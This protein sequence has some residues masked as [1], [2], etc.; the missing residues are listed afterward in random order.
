MINMMRIDGIRQSNSN[1]ELNLRD[2][3][4]GDEED[5]SEI[6]GGLDRNGE[7]WTNYFQSRRNRKMNERR[8]FD[9]RTDSS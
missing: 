6:V 3:L 7:H 9:V 8:G 1:E 2:M 5:S 4:Y